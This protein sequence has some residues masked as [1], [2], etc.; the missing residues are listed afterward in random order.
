M[1]LVKLFSFY[2]AVSFS[3]EEGCFEQLVIIGY[4]TDLKMNAIPTALSFPDFTC[5]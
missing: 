2:L 4:T 5:L 3:T 1:L